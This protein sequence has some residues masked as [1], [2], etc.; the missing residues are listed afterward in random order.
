MYRRFGQSHSRLLVTR[1]CNITDLE[2]QIR[3]LDK[4]DDEGGPDTQFRLKNRYF[5]EGFDTQK[6]DLLEK[7][8]KEILAYGRV[9]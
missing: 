3:N 9:F 7:L 6:R 1:Q 8:E 4:S 2:T 5:E